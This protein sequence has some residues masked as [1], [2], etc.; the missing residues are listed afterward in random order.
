MAKRL[1]G[2][3]VG[4]VGESTLVVAMR[5]PAN[6]VAIDD[7]AMLAGYSVRPAVATRDDIQGLI[8][9]LDRFSGSV[10]EDPDE[11]DAVDVADLA[12]SAGNEPVIKLAN[13]IIARPSSSAPPTS[14][15]RPPSSVSKCGCE[16]TG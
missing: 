9:R 1:E 16:S 6:V 12:E 13:S 2:V 4:F 15:S 14:T 5:D 7:M 10:E 11:D 3:P 8:A